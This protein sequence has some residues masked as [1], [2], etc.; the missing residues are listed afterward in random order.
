M[1]NM[2]DQTNQEKIITCTDCSK[3]L[4]RVRRYYKNGKYYCNKS[5]YR[6]AKEKKQD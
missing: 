1:N 2:A 3:Q 5:C 4:K 6:K